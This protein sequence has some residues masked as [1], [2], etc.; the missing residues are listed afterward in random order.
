MKGRKERD[1]D[2]QRYNRTCE[3][4]VIHAD[5]EENDTKNGRG[6]DKRIQMHDRIRIKV[7]GGD[8]FEPLDNA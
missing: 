2:M 4:L 6:S 8:L 3:R 5:I 1:N 7:H